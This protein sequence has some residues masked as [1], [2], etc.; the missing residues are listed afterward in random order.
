MARPGNRASVNH[1]A[2]GLIAEVPACSEIRRKNFRPPRI[3][4]REIRKI[5]VMN[6]R[7]SH[8][9]LASVLAV[10]AAAVLVSAPSRCFA[11][12]GQ[13]IPPPD[14]T[15]PKWTGPDDGF[16]TDLANWSE[17]WEREEAFRLIIDKES[18]TRVF[19]PTGGN[20]VS[21]LVLQGKTGLTITGGASGSSSRGTFVFNLATG[22]GTTGGG[23]LSGLS[24]GNSNLMTMDVFCNVPNGSLRL[25]R[26][27]MT[28]N[29]SGAGRVS[30]F[31]G[32]TF[33]A[34]PGVTRQPNTYTGGTS[35]GG[36][37]TVLASAGTTPLGTGEVSFT[38]LNDAVTYTPLPD[39]GGIPSLI[40]GNG[41]S[42]TNNLRLN[43]PGLIKS[44]TDGG[45][46]V[47]HITGA[48]DLSGEALLLQSTGSAVTTAGEPD[49][50]VSGPLTMA[51]S[52]L[53]MTTVGGDML[54]DGAISGTASEVVVE[55]LAPAPSDRVILAGANNFTAPIRVRNNAT[56]QVSGASNIGGSSNNITMSGH[57]VLQRIGGGDGSFGNNDIICEDQA[58]IRTLRGTATTLFSLRGPGEAVLESTGASTLPGRFTL[59]PR[60]GTVSKITVGANTTLRVLRSSALGSGETELTG[61]TATLELDPV[62]N[63]GDP[64]YGSRTVRIT[65]G[66][67]LTSTGDAHFGATVTG[68]GRLTV[69]GTPGRTLDLTDANFSGCPEVTLR[70][71]TVLASGGNI[72]GSSSGR[73]E[74]A[75]QTSTTS[76]VTLRLA[77]SLSIAGTRTVVFSNAIIDTNGKNFTITR[78]VTNTTLR[79]TGAGKLVVAATITGGTLT[80]DGGSLGGTGTVPALTL[81]SGGTLAP[82]NS[83]GSLTAGSCVWQQGAVCDFE[84]GTLGSSDQLLLNG[85][86]TGDTDTPR[87]FRFTGSPTL[88]VYT[89]IRRADGSPLTTDFEASDFTFIAPPGV[90]GVFTVDSTG[91]KFSITAAPGFAPPTLSVANAAAVPE[92][93]A[94]TFTVTL[95]P[96]ATVPVTVDYAAVSGS[97][98]QGADFAPASGTLTFAAGETTKTI[99]VST[100]DDVLD[101]PSQTYTITLSDPAFATLG[102]ASAT[103]SITDNDDPP[104]L[105]ADSISVGEQ[106]GDVFLTFTLSAPSEQSVKFDAA[107]TAG[108]AAGGGVDFKVADDLTNIEIPAGETSV[109]LKAAASII[110]DPNFEGLETFTVSVAGA[111]GAS[112]GASGTVTITDN[113]SAP[114]LSPRVSHVTE[115][116]QGGERIA[117]VFFILSTLT[118]SQVPLTWSASTEDDTAIAG[119]DYVAI[120]DMPVTLDSGD[121]LIELP[122]RILASPQV[123][124]D[125][126]F[127]LRLT[128]TGNAAPGIIRSRIHIREL[129]T[130]SLSV[131][132]DGSVVIEYPFSTSK[133]S[134]LF[135]SPDLSSWIQA[136][137]FNG[138]IGGSGLRS[139]TLPAATHGGPRRFFKVEETGP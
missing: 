74:L 58:T 15:P 40:L 121:L 104:V 56:L 76:P 98:V 24:Q 17:D 51:E 84:L 103:G 135:S 13:V 37:L 86:L 53:I 127:L 117:K 38:D 99:T 48:I 131:Q 50:R 35:I 66:G 11:Q 6:V 114:A 138:P 1:S 18:V 45:T 100:L 134:R 25:Y 108:T 70:S 7:L 105:S 120:T 75:G 118:S 123:E 32:C 5:P 16:F 122:V 129:L 81:E 107:L 41:V 22:Q 27:R 49:L 39:F 67:T 96:A 132:P 9:S 65:G 42:I 33:D 95:S 90:A 30:V 97:A 101:E 3:L 59:A 4:R 26:T 23:Q 14:L 128:P 125:E 46:V 2:T 106:D 64:V 31:H 79:K 111:S 29:I 112:I 28:Q 139:V 85:A 116:P 68:T 20:T 61:S 94:Q 82:G 126:S 55:N 89:L 110:D 43:S 12:G 102:T 72:F 78:P 92:G 62:A 44:G 109:A 137:Q 60:G 63:L 77:N 47:P 136:D 52:Q 130:R 73:F 19:H 93:S 8:P 10:L 124:E 69:S 54:V 80:V 91:V 36:E 88:S 113:D 83:I 133:T 119:E 34:L 115:S 57:S 87:Q 21:A 71:G